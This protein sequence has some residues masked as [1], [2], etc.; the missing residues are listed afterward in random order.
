MGNVGLRRLAISKKPLVIVPVVLALVLAGLFLPVKVSIEPYGR[1]SL[2]SKITITIGYEAV[3]ASPGWISPTG[4]V[5][6][7]GTWSNEPLAYDEDTVTYATETIASAGWGNYLELTHSAL[8]CD[9]VQVWS[10]YQASVDLI[11]IDVY[12]SGAWNNI[13]SGAVT[14]GQYVEYAIGSEQSVTAM[15]IRYHTTKN[16]RWVRIYEADFNEVSLVP[17]ISNLPTSKDFG[18]VSES[19]PYWSNGSAPVWPLDDTECFFTVTNNGDTSSI[20]IEATDFTGGVG[21]TLASSPG[22]NIV[23]LKVGKSGDAN[24][25]AMVTV[26]TSPQAFISGLV[27]SMKWELKMETPTSNTDGVGKTSVMTLTATLD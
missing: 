4:F 19:T 25:D 5:D 16:N 18:T 23:T 24:E 7:G 2:E 10:S 11:E 13:Y 20:T 14:I 26:T 12:Y 21:W 3:Y 8:N 22:E 9:K 17:D 1:L 6:G 27:T 15:R